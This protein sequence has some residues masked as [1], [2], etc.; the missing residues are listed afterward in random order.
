MKKMGIG[1][2]VFSAPLSGIAN[3]SKSLDK[4]KESITEFSLNN[5][6]FEFK[7]SGDYFVGIGQVKTNGLLLR[8]SKLPMFAQ[9]STPEAIELT[10]F[11]LTDKIVGNDGIVLNFT[12]Q[13]QMGNT[14]EWM[15]H[16]VRNRQNISD[17]TRCAEDA[18]GTL[19]RLYIYEF[20][21]RNLGYFSE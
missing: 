2:V 21:R 14:M 20:K 19:T 15:L 6:D 17:W 18:S 7:F 16:T 5:F 4:I 10:N 13:Q 1:A 12:A 8:S 9:V 11:K 3:S